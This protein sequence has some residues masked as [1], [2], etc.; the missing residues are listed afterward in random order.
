MQGGNLSSSQELIVI[1]LD[2]LVACLPVLD[3][4]IFPSLTF[5]CFCETF[6]ICFSRFRVAK[7]SVLHAVHE[8]P[9][10]RISFC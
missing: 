8:H 2:W 10:C 4:R 5:Q 6:S 9:Q 7:E 1:R 3:G